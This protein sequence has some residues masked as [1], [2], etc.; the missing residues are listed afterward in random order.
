MKIVSIGAGPAGL[1]FSILFKKAHPDAVVQV[2]ER[3]RAD[4]TF[5]WG[6]VFSD[7][8][9]DNFQ[10]ADPESFASIRSNFA[11]W[12]NIETYYGGELVTST[13]HGFCGLARKK[14]LQI[15]HERC[16]ELGVELHFS[17]EVDNLDQFG[18]ADLIL[19]ADGINS[20]V[21]ET[22]AQHFK[23]SLD[24]RRNKFCWLGTSL[25]LEAFTFIFLE[26]EHGLFRVHAYPFQRGDNPLST[27]IVEC[28]EATWKRAGLDQTSE[29]QTV[30]YCEDLFADYLKGHPLLVNRSV[31]RTFPTV[32][33]ESWHHENIVILGDAAHTAHFSIGSG[34]KLAMEDAIALNEAFSQLG[35]N[36]VPRVLA[37]YQDSRWVDSIKI[38]KA[39]QT[40][41]EWFENTERYTKQDPIQFSFNLMTRSKRITWDNLELRDPEL[42]RQVREWYAD[43]VGAAPNSD[44]SVPVPIFTPFAARDLKLKN[45]IVVSPMC[46]YSAKDGTPGDWHLMHLGARATGGAGLLF[47]EA[48]NVSSE[49]RITHGCTGMYT[50]EH[51]RAWK[52][53]VDFV[54]EHTQTKIGMQLGHAGRKASC[55][56]PWEG[57]DPL[58]DET[59]WPT[60]GPSADAF[61]RGWHVPKQMDRADMDRVRAEFV[62]AAERCEEAGFDTIELHMAHGYL[63]SSFISPKSNHRQDEYGGSLENRMR[64][65]LEV[66]EAVRAVWPKSKPIFVRLSA[67]DWLDDA[68]GLTIDDSVQVALALKQRGCDVIDV[69]SAG[70]TPESQVEYGRMYQAPFAEQ[71]RAEAEIPVMAVGAIL[72][73]DHANTLL[74]AGR[75]DLCAMARP[76]LVNPHTTLQAAVQ[77]EHYDQFWPKPYLAAKP[78]PRTD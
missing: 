20:M 8:T 32:R 37:A 12:P 28:S 77:Y 68:G 55:N 44:G 56:L 69:S 10:R 39:A 30:A 63:L 52:R 62:R 51:T 61:D 54:H 1:Y 50:D 16:V 9:L 76:H 24:W 74:A 46:M 18:D 6:V 22:H 26:N 65:P 53:I 7:E 5:G 45:R 2:F 70:N 36:D 17:A 27:F 67:S 34:T 14:L 75:T 66:F 42:V 35:L 31:W 3:N 21:R 41:L 38:Q 72:G 11:Y 60:L 29:E 64:Y 71:I 49:G 48:T 58:K 40:S 33:N 13:G 57:D 4:D 25:P 47:T 19:G 78:K 59:A 43:S 23:P 15:F 73:A